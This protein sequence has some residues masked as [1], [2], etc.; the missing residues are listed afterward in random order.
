MP[1]HIFKFCEHLSWPKE[2]E[3]TTMQE[4]ETGT[5]QEGEIATMQEGET[6]QEE[7][8]RLEPRVCKGFR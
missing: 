1:F 4:G 7:T 2:G 6:V 8:F 3:P 5:M